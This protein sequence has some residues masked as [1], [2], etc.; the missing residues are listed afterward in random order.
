M[1]R[2]QLLW[3]CFLL[4]APSM[5]DNLAVYKKGLTKAYLPMYNLDCV[6]FHNVIFI[7]GKRIK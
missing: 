1:I 6:Y 4:R 5:G 7:R 3:S 2:K